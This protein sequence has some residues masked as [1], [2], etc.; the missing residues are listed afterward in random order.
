MMEARFYER[1]DDDIRCFLCPHHCIILEG[2]TGI[3]NVRR[4][5]QGQLIAETFENLSAVNFDPVEKKPLY[6]Y[7]PGRMV[8]SLGSKG[9]NMRCKCCQNWQISQAPTQGFAFDRTMTPMEVVKLARTR[10]SNIG[11]AYTYNE[12]TVWFEYMLDI[13]RLVKFDG[14][15]N[16]MVSNG[17]INTKPLLELL[18][19]LDAF[20]IDLK[21]FSEDFYR[22]FTGATLQPVLQTLQ[23]I[24]KA[25]KHLEITF[26]VVPE[27]NDNDA[28]F[29]GMV[30]WIS[31]ELGEETV[32][33][34]SRYHPAFKLDLA[35][36]S[37]LKLQDLY[38]V[39]REK[40]KYVYVGNIQM[41]DCQNT[42]C[43]KCGKLVIQRTGYQ[44]NTEFLTSKGACL[45][46]G[47][48]VAHL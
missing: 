7:Y 25:G 44:V 48:P 33:H 16:I 18:Y 32:L 24:R 19:Y 2:K 42:M 17:F 37:A 4:N 23:N 20:N 21:G 22:K 8:L 11:V 40:L 12:P 3:C 1:V 13:A 41:K 14:F 30:S 34:L 45:Y 39:A 46:C 28:E 35:P 9:C 47:N 43:S 6:H 15:K 29:R 5:I 10:E 26:L 38:G 27:W 31:N 36:T